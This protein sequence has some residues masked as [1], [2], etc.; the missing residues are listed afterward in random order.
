NQT[1]E[2]TAIVVNGSVVGFQMTKLGTG[3]TTPPAVTIT[4]QNGGSGLGTIT[5]HL[6]NGPN[7]S[8]P[9]DPP[10]P[11]NEGYRGYIGEYNSADGKVYAGLQPYHQ[12]TVQL[13]LVF[14]DGARLTF[15][16]N[17]T[18]PL[19][20]EQDPSNPIQNSTVWAYDKNAAAYMV[21]DTNNPGK[22]PPEGT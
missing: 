22:P 15:A 7:P 18:N 12:V 8:A 14:W 20:N 11:P 10:D 17:G 2:A 6:A 1:A 9:Y 21:T 19:L 13:P 16:S 3:Y 4:N 5:A